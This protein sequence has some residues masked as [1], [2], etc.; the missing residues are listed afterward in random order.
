MTLTAWE[1]AAR[2]FEPPPSPTDTDDGSLWKT[3]GWSAFL[4]DTSRL[5]LDGPDGAVVYSLPGVDLTA[6]SGGLEPS[7]CRSPAPASEVV[8]KTRGA[9]RTMFARTDSELTISGPAG[10]GKSLPCLARVHLAASMY[11]GVRCLVARKTA[12]SLGSTTLVTFEKKVAKEA[13]AAGLLEWYGGSTREA[14]SYRYVNGSV[15]VVGGLDKPIKVMSAEYDLVFVDEATELVV[16]DWEAIGTRLGRNRVLPWQQQIGALNPGPPTHWLKQRADAGMPML[17]SLH[18]DNPA[19]FTDDGD[20]TEAGLAYLEILGKLTGVRRLRLKDGLWAAAEGV[21]YDE[22]QDAV[23]LIDP[24]EVPAGW[25]R[26][27]S[28]DFGYVHPFVLQCWAEDDDGRLYLYREIYMTDRLVEDH[29]RTILDAVRDEQGGWTEPRPRAVICDH[30]AE[31][32]ATLERHLGMSTV[33]AN[34]NVTEGIQAF[35]GRL[36]PAGDGKPRLF[37]M[38][39]CTLERDPVLVDAKKPASTAEEIPGYVWDTSGGKKPKEAPV[40]EMDDGCD[41]GRYLVAERDLGAR[42]R[43]RWV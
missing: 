5:R 24:F 36:R 13:L 22:W 27:W 40:K 21:I 32:R 3:N 15:I 14:A 23:H 20:P 28:V 43:V 35:A 17:H 11:P 31:G 34:K 4:E 38:R 1:V 42:P 6:G 8:L 18:R 37:I 30:D 2:H 16:D 19:L 9:A 12:V 39:G 7:G 29:A 25:T 10:T 26:W 33:A 41:A